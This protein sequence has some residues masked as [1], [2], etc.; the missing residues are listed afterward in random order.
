MENNMIS[1]LP[2]QEFM[3]MTSVQGKLRVSAPRSIFYVYS[4]I[5]LTRFTKSPKLLRLSIC[6]ELM[7]ALFPTIP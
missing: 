5:W 3:S 6:V 7:V 1:L 2:L 4:F